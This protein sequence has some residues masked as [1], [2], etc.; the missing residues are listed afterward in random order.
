MEILS[1][2]SKSRG[3]ET[4]AACGDRLLSY[5]EET[6]LAI[7]ENGSGSEVLE[8]PKHNFTVSNVENIAASRYVHGWKLFIIISSLCL[9][10][11]LV[12]LDVSIIGVA[13][14]RITTDFHTLNDISWYGSA[15]LLGVTALQPSFGVLYKLF[16]VKVVYLISIVVF[17]VGSIICAISANSPTFIVGRAISGIGAAGLFQGAL[18]I[19]AYTVIIE[20]RP[21]Y[22]GFLVGMFG[23]SVCV[24][25][26][27]GGTFTDHV[28]WR[29]CFWINVPIGGVTLISILAFLELK[30]SDGERQLPIKEKLKF[31]DFFGTISF[32]GAICCLLLALQWGG[33]T[34]PWNSPKI[35]CLFVGSF[36]LLLAFS[37]TQWKRGETAIIPLRVL[38]QR[39]V[40]NGALF[41]FFLGMASIV[42]AY[43]M[44][45]YFQSIQGV[46]ATESGIRFIAL[47]APQIIATIIVGGI[48]SKFGYYVPFM[49]G[50]TAISIVGYGL[51]TTLSVGTATKIWATY[52]VIN[53]IGMGS[54]MNVPYTAL[55]AVLS[56]NDIPTGNAISVFFW[57]LGGAIAASISQSIFIN[58]I[59]KRVSSQ[60]PSLDPSAVISA[61]AANLEHLASN[62]D[63]LQVLRQIYA[64]ALR[65]V[66]I[67]ALVAACLA[68]LFTLGMEW[69]NLKDASKLGEDQRE[70]QNDSN[71]KDGRGPSY[72]A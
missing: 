67:Y 65:E 42:Y 20:K 34:E 14:P 62:A 36:L 51:L 54:G 64:A 6:K 30:I 35:I 1:P 25:P 71:G 49:I 12:A 16:D 55:Q 41:L 47:V 37:Y 26:L 13:I 11:F 23:I 27:L 28:S 10:T 4:S 69:L 21:L 43:Y 33:E 63:I 52:L 29:W 8:A 7:L 68:F 58:G 17:E 48:I 60:L 53:G 57:Q 72:I 45:I 9:G 24:G 61:G 46:S 39:S 3:C 59:S 50:G 18:G 32:V 66:F 22:L 70:A 19:V 31:M 2:D 5:G 44:P 40:L 15:Y 38:R 56:D